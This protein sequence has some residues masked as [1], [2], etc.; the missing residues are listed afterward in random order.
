MPACASF[1]FHLDLCESELHLLNFAFVAAHLILE[2]LDLR[3]NVAERNFEPRG[4]FFDHLLIDLKAGNRGVGGER[5]DSTYAC[6]YRRVAD[7]LER[8]DVPR[9]PDVRT[10]AKLG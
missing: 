7:D 8:A 6:C 1:H 2:L 9:S 10:A 5:F 4:Q 3:R